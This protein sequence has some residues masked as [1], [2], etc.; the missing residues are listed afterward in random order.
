MLNS[1]FTPVDHCIVTDQS[2]SQIPPDRVQDAPTS[3]KF[4]DIE[5][6]SSD[7]E[8]IS[9]PSFITQGHREKL[10]GERFEVIVL[11]KAL[12]FQFLAKLV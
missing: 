9:D 12:I 8:I 1:G 4:H 7:L 11:T 2:F 6:C 10:A 5:L 3:T